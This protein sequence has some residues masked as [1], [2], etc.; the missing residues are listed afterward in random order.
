MTYRYFSAP[1]AVY[2]QVR[3]GL[4]EAWG[5]PNDKGTATCFLRASEAW[6]GADGNCL[7]CVNAEWCE[8]P[9][10][11]AVLP[12]LLANGAV[13]EITEAEYWQADPSGL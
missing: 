2:E 12:S 11:L 8:Y 3:I 9:E 13:R 4:N 1:E 6:R 5:L 7:L 10:V